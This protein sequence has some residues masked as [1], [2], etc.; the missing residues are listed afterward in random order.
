M[1]VDSLNI[2]HVAGTKGKGSTCAFIESFLRAHGQKTGFPRKT[3]LY[4]SPHLIFPEERIRINLQP[5]ARHLFAEYLFQVW[6]AL[7]NADGNFEAPLPRYLQLLALMSFHAFIKECVEAAIF[8][9]HH[10]GEF[11]ATNVIEHPVVTV[12]TPLGMDHVEQLGPG[13]ENIAWHKAG[14]FKSGSTTVSSL[15]SH[16]DAGQVLRNRVNEK[17]D[18]IHF[19]E[20]DSCLP[21]D[22][23]QLKPY[24]QRIKFASFYFKRM[25][26]V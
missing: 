22:A 23:P 16:A 15:Q 3:G 25:P 19:V 4:T 9:T 20:R 11:N 1:E 2:I 7:T 26:P 21:P 14:I 12:I 17:S 18:K 5:I 6:D 10:G 24:I 13:I 8:D